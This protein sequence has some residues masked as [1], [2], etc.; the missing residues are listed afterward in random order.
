MPLWQIHHPENAW[1]ESEK[2][3]FVNAITAIYTDIVGIPAFYV[4]VIFKEVESGDLWVSGRPQDTFV[5]LNIDQ[6]ARTLPGRV[7]REWWV[8]HLDEVIKPWV[9]D[10]GFD[11]EFTITEPPADL[12]S[13]QGFVPPPFESVGEARWVK[14]NKASEYSQAEQLP[15][16]VRLTAGTRESF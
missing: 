4:V 15:I 8:H 3:E 10:K 5:R 14:E 9:A 13:L 1:N 16:N 6:T 11:W 7:L 2:Q 12:W